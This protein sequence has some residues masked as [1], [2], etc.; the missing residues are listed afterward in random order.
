MISRDFCFRQ[1]LQCPGACLAKTKELFLRWATFGS[2]SQRQL[3]LLQCP[4]AWKPTLIHPVISNSQ[5]FSCHCHPPSQQL[6]QRW[7]D[8][9]IPWK[10]LPGWTK[11]GSTSLADLVRWGAYPQHQPLLLLCQ[12]HQWKS[13]LRT[14]FSPEKSCL[15]EPSQGSRSWQT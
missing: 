8:K 5:N 12:Q 3:P 6:R 13:L 11:S 14:S 15:V 2:I 7:D 10:V 4:G 1:L 9:T